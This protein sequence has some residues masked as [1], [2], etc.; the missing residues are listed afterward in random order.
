MFERERERE[1]E[2]EWE[3]EREDGRMPLSMQSAPSTSTKHDS[4][5]KKEWSS[6]R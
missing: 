2:S 6:L 1:K 4:E 3:R 5:A